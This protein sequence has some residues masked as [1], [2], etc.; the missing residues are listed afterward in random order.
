[1]VLKTR[2]DQPMAHQ[3]AAHIRIAHRAAF[4][5]DRGQRHYAILAT[6]GRGADA[7][8]C[9]SE[10]CRRR[11][12]IRAS[13][14][15]SGVGRRARV[16]SA[17]STASVR[18]A[19]LSSTIERSTRRATAFGASRI[20]CMGP[21]PLT[22]HGRC[23]AVEILA[24]SGDELRIGHFIRR[25]HPGDPRAPSLCRSSRFLNSPLASPGPRI[26]RASRLATAEITW[27]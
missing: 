17:P 27:S 3:S 4:L 6:L 8:C 14:T 20:I 24:D 2:A 1:M 23:R 5:D 7:S 11:I 18:C 16:D 13:W 21:A 26:S 10:A 19:S 9:R 25:L 12:E 22:T 15:A